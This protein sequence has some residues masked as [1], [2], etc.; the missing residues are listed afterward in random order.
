VADET[1]QSG[2][3]AL[4]A[5]ER[6]TAD[7]QKLC[8]IGLNSLLPVRMLRKAGFRSLGD[9]WADTTTAHGGLMPNVLG[10]LAEFERELISRPHRRRTGA[11]QG[12]RAELG[13]TLQA[14]H[15]PAWRGNYSPPRRGETPTDIARSYNVHPSPIS[16]LR[17]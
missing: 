1:R 7:T 14:H 8:Y 2:E 12:T 6:V 10:G 16:R 9:A 5:S 3:S 17:A 15:A 11:R 4:R 13:P